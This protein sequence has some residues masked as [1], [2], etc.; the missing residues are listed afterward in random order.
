MDTTK[1][2]ETKLQKRFNKQLHQEKKQSCGTDS[3]NYHIPP[4]DYD[5]IQ[6]VAKTHI[7]LTEEIVRHTVVYVLKDR[8]ERSDS[9]LLDL[10]DDLKK[11]M[12][13][14]RLIKI[15]LS[16]YN[17]NRTDKVLF[18]SES[19]TKDK[20]VNE[21]EQLVA[22][23]LISKR[24][25]FSHRWSGPI[26]NG[27]LFDR[28]CKMQTMIMLCQNR[29]QRLVEI[30]KTDDK[31]ESHKILRKIDQFFRYYLE[32]DRLQHEKHRHV[33]LCIHRQSGINL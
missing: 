32:N 18:G 7:D 24:N 13:L 5:Y 12:T 25:S 8:K 16:R 19:L 9:E 11:N 14:G 2:K 28:Y 4:E 6:G 1:S 22:Q 33:I 23:N 29:I 15:L 17:W 3:L 10:M 27:N 31:C 21:K 26:E 20:I 30:I